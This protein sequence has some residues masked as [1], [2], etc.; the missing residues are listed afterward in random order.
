MKRFKAQ[1]AWLIVMLI[2]TVLMSSSLAYGGSDE[3]GRN[4]TT[5]DALGAAPLFAGYIGGS[6][7]ANQGSYRGVTRDI[8][9]TAASTL[10]TGSHDKGA[11]YTETTSP[12]G[13]VN[14][15][16]HTANPQCQDSCRF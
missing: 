9:T 2:L 14:G 11:V 15:T 13:T 7:M 16:I 4:H 8:G 3:H 5:P 1:K 12:I 6:G 10:V